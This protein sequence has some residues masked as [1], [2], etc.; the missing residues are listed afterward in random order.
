M[1]AAAFTPRPSACADRASGAYTPPAC[2][3]AR[4]AMDESPT[5]PTVHCARCN[6]TRD[7]LDAPPFRAGSA[8]AALGREL[9]ARVCA[10]CY[11]AWLA[12]SVKLVN[13]TRLDLTDAHGRAVWLAQMRA[14]LNLAEPGAARDP[15]AR[16]LDQR[17]A[18][19]TLSG[20][21]VRGTVVGL[22]DA[23]LVLADLD[24]DAP[25]LTRDANVCLGSAAIARDAVLVIEP[26]EA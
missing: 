11:R 1:P 24:R 23:R 3:R 16:F 21:R 17:V 10:E 25:E 12:A 9:H 18:L 14:F 5:A 7:A 2:H 19:E 26:I 13:E 4:A 20:A 22:D 6:Q 15:W 8:L